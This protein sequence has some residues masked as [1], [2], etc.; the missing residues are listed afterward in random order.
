MATLRKAGDFIGPGEQTTAAY[1]EKQLPP[2]WVI[3]ANKEL[4]RPDGSVRELDFIVMGEHCLFAVEEKSWSGP[5]HGDENGWVLRSGASYRNPIDVVEM[6][7][8]RLAG[9]VQDRVPYLK[10][11]VSGHFVYSRVL[12]SD[13]NADPSFI[14]DPR[15]NTHVLAL[16]GC[17]EEFLRIDQHQAGPGSINAY[18]KKIVDQLIGLPDRPRIPRKVGEFEILEVVSTTDTVRCLRARH[19]DGSERLLKLVERP[20][21]AISE[22]LEEQTNL[23][24]R[25]YEALRL[26]AQKGCVPQIDPYF[27]WSD[28]QFWV[29]PHHPIPGR[30]LRATRTSQ[31][32]TQKQL[33]IVFEQAFSALADIHET[34]TLHRAITPD[35]LYLTDDQQIVFTDFALARIRN[36]NTIAPILDVEAGQSPYQAKECQEVG[37]GFA[38]PQSDVFSLTASLLYWATGFEPPAF[39]SMV[40]SLPDD[41][42]QALGSILTQCLEIDDERRRPLAS[43]VVQAIQKARSNDMSPQF[44]SVP[45]PVPAGTLRPGTEVENQYRIVRKLGEGGTA[46]TY[47]ADDLVTDSRYVLKTIKSPE[48]ITRLSKA[49]F[50][51]LKE[52]NHPNLPRIFDIRPAN[53]PFHLKIEYISGSPLSDVMAANC[54]NLDFCLRVGREM[55]DAL[56]HLAEHK[57]LHRD[58]SPSN[59]LIPDTDNAPIRLI[60]FG[61]ASATE[62]TQTAVGTPLYR[63]PEIDRGG[64]W[65]VQCDLYSL[66]VVLFELLTGRLPYVLTERG[67]PRKD[68]ESVYDTSQVSEEFRRVVKVLRKV[69]SFDPNQRYGSAAEVSEALRLARI[70]K[71]QSDTGGTQR[72]N[73]FVKD[74]RSVYRNSRL[75]NAENRGLDSQ[76]ARKTYVQTQL[77]RELLP[78]IL[79]RTLKLVILSGNPG[80][81][82]TTFLAKVAEEVNR[83]KGQPISRDDSG[84][85]MQ[86]GGHQF[87]ALYDASESHKDQ[88][89]DALMHQLLLPLAGE[90]EPRVH[91]TALIAANDGRLLDFFERFGKEHYPWLWSHLQQ[92]LFDGKPADSGVVLV[93]LKSRSLTGWQQ[94]ETSLFSQILD[95]FVRPDRWAI[96]QE[97]VS[98]RECPMYFN[99]QSLQDPVLKPGIVR[100][101][102]RMLL[103]VHLKRE[104]R[105]TVR[106]LRS[107]LAFLLTHDTA[108]EEIH[109]ERNNNNSPLTRL[110]RLYFN[111]AFNG[112]GSPDLLLDEWRQLDPAYIAQP[113]LDRYF[114]FHRKRDQEDHIHQVFLKPRLRQVPDLLLEVMRD[115]TQQ[116]GWLEQLKRWYFFEASPHIPVSGRA[117]P[118]PDRLLPYRY[119]DDFLAALSNQQH[120]HKLLSQLAGGM[121]RAD[122]VP[123]KASEGFLAFRMNET[124]T[125]DFTVV[126]QFPLNEF[127]VRR[128]ATQSRYVEA[129]SDQLLFRYQNGYH[130]LSIGLDLF[131]FLQRAADGLVAGAEEQKAM[132]EDLTLFK[133]MLLANPTRQVTLIEAGRSIHQVSIQDGKIVREVQSK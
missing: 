105:P 72:E 111:A 126:K 83:Q 64:Y 21:T 114:H 98:R 124:E 15:I 106:D 68:Q 38:E 109:Q 28:G 125:L 55:L 69:T 74:L 50:A 33:W 110:E 65:R 129:I 121:S 70:P 88:S 120:D 63:A 59:I 46:I 23:I 67:V 40:G 80:D 91:Y 107:A 103:A 41:F 117:L 25:E 96:C 31:P 79:S 131:E 87:A 29:F 22:L 76:F 54:G 94:E 84:W 26:L 27:S 82:K 19:E 128:S 75:G 1:L 85:V 18:R 104:R 2:S 77:D 24:K 113:R 5:I 17:E 108:C 102:H 62:A 47:L 73:P 44:S 66:G 7:A 123:A 86:I 133:N 45:T 3:I 39:G 112:S 116:D 118:Q 132:S 9:I 35:S 43:E 57:I 99:V 14:H 48:L 36:R 101:L 56:H 90:T 95:E 115:V 60:D 34:G 93:D 92:Q 16:D 53:S 13:S 11:Q 4:V 12:L 52:L 6:N 10:H 97:C 37:L 78:Q 30:T 100:Q 127:E 49:E 8:R 51:A 32:P 42:Q 58:I 61:L 119:F 81:G 89:A 71:Y 122:G 20:V 130:Q